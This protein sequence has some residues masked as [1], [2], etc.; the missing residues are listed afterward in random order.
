MK[1]SI[2]IYVLTFL[3]AASLGFGVVFLIHSLNS[4]PEAKANPEVIEPLAEY[5]AIQDSLQLEEQNNEPEMAPE[6]EPHTQK[7]KEDS[8]KEE[9]IIVPNSWKLSANN[10]GVF[11]VSGIKYTGSISGNVS[12]RL[13]LGDDKGVPL[14][15]SG[16]N[17]VF[18]KNNRSGLFNDVPIISNLSEYN[19][20]SYNMPK[21]LKYWIEVTDLDNSSKSKAKAGFVY[22]NRLSKNELESIINEKNGDAFDELYNNIRYRLG[23]PKVVCEGYSDVKN[24]VA[25]HSLFIENPELETKKAGITSIM[26]NSKTGEVTSLT[27]AIQ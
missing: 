26:Y 21:K 12:Y 24:L 13:F 17:K 23:S 5:S 27:I 22:V 20:K 19:Q 8:A 14:K 4:K 16:G 1:N 11:S 9:S 6:T 7:E 18:D 10:D 2:I 15:D 3:I 25:V